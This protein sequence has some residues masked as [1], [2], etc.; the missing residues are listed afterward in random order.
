MPFTDYKKVC[1]EKQAQMK[2]R[3][4]VDTSRR[5]TI[6]RTPEEWKQIVEEANRKSGTRFYEADI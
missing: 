4:R 6:Q 3:Q 2:E 5:V 1:D